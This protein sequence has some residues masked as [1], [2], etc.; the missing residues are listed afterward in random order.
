MEMIAL[1]YRD[2]REAGRILGSV[3]LERGMK[4]GA[5]VLALPRGGV[6]VGFEAARV[7]D[8]ELDVF[9]VRKLGT[10]GYEELAMGAIASGG[11]RVLNRDVVRELHISEQ[12]IDRVAE[13]EATE[14]RRREEAYRDGRPAAAITGRE[15]ALVDDGLATGASMRAALR[16]LKQLSPAR[17]VVAAPVAA[18]ETCDELAAEAD[19]VICAATPEPFH[20]VGLWYRDFR[21]T[22]D[23]EVR[24]LLA[25][26]WA[27]RR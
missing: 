7:I 10:P 27:I 13:R 23:D 24:E 22:E 16:A 2:R 20:A 4:R 17:V 8:G 26:A 6:P 3:M 19:A 18:A 15:V 9:L 5:L 11:E 14:L 21:P 12:A 25:E 1:P